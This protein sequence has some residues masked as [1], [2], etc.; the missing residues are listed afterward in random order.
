MEI[1]KRVRIYINDEDRHGHRSLAAA[2]LAF[3]KDEN[4]AGATL[5][6]A[7]EGFGASG[8]LHSSRLADVRWNLPIVIEWIVSRPDTSACLGSPN[9]MRHSSRSIENV[10]CTAVTPASAGATV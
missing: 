9:G 8:D 7:T 1:A 6:R 5:Y 10:P 3:L 2:L 4:A